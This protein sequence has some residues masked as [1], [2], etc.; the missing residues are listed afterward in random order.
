[1]R[2]PSRP[3]AANT[4]CLMCGGTVGA[5]ACCACA[6]A[7]TC[8]SPRVWQKNSTR[9]SVFFLSFQ[10]PARAGGDPVLL[11]H[12]S[13]GLPVFF[14]FLQYQKRHSR[15]GAYTKA[16]SEV[17]E[18]GRA[19]IAL[20]LTTPTPALPVNPH[21]PLKRNCPEL[22]LRCTQKNFTRALSPD[23]RRGL[24]RTTHT[25]THTHTP[26]TLALTHTHRSRLS[27]SCE[28]GEALE[29]P[30]TRPPSP[31]GSSKDLQQN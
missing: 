9:L 6:C 16:S 24:A 26:H 21:L 2:G 19:A 3:T 30:C 25:H 20:T 22:R 15:G 13:F 12:P 8:P 1:V 31:Q 17:G 18:G 29:L 4:S 7:C 14:P 27:D 5:C 23:T 10:N 11:P 28:D